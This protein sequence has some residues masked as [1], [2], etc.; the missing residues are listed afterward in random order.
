M[1]AIILAA[2]L[3]SR[4]NEFGK[5]TPKCMIT[6]FGKTLLERQIEI[7]HNCGISEITVVTGH[8]SNSINY[9]DVDYI[10]NP[11]YSTTNMNESLFCAREKFDDSILISY[12]DIIYE[13]KIIEKILKSDHD[14]SLGVRLDWRKYYENR[15]QH[16]LSEAENV[17]IDDD[18]IINLKKNISSC[19][20]NQDIGEFLGIIKMT[21]KGIRQL[22][23]KYLELKNKNLGKFHTSESLEQA[24]L[25]DML[26]E[27]IDCGT[28]LN[29]V[30]LNDLWFEIDTTEDL[31]KAEK[32]L[33]I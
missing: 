31:R 20:Y 3:G 6:I 4:L 29:P 10:K 12:S 13:Q 25:T 5:K 33:K 30:I 22:L 8:N 26:Q 18:R 28:I 14:F 15:T 23:K 27:M 7:F 16:P 24:Y 19:S 9:P 11:N 1:K 2:G 17:V 32:L 21:K